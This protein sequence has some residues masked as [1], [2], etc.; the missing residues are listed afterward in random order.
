MSAS[1]VTASQLRAIHNQMA[2]TSPEKTRA[3]LLQMAD[4]S[5]MLNAETYRLGPWLSGLMVKRQANF[6]IMQRY[7]QYRVQQAD[8]PVAQDP[9]LQRALDT[10]SK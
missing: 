9:T 1:A 8:A 2:A 5:L 7:A 10:F 4:H 6:E 3:A